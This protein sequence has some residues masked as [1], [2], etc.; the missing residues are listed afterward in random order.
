M[1][2]VMP[3]IIRI[4]GTITFSA[5]IAFVVVAVCIRITQMIDDHG[6]RN[7]CD[8]QDTELIRLRVER[9]A[10]Y[11]VVLAAETI[12]LK[13]GP[14]RSC[15]ECRERH[16]ATRIA[17]QHL[18]KSGA[19]AENFH[20]TDFDSCQT[21]YEC[22]EEQILDAV[23]NLLPPALSHPLVQAKLKEAHIARL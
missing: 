4:L 16:E 5:V 21:C 7:L 18:E 23:R 2:A 17:C 11:A 10:L 19:V 15:D 6:N 20:D 14:F 8:L 1:E 12:L 9:D 13:A 22:H 3:Q